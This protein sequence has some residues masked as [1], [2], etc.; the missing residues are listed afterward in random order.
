M[1][2]LI[3]HNLEL[4]IKVIR[5]FITKDKQERYMQFISSPKNR[6]KFIKDLAHFSFLRKELFSQVIGNKDESVNQILNNLKA[7]KISD[8]NCYVIS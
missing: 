4:E 1:A 6:V 3:M 7:N 2:S 8:A 5:N